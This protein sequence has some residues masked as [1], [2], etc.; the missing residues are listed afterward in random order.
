MWFPMF[1]DRDCLFDL[2]LCFGQFPD[3]WWKL[4]K[5][6]GIYYNGGGVLNHEEAVGVAMGRNDMESKIEYSCEKMEQGECEW[7]RRVILEIFKLDPRERMPAVKV[8]CYVPP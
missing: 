1:G 7:S 5:D 8:V 2:G 4:W 3:S 6:R